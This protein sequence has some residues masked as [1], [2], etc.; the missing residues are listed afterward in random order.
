MK[1]V[2]LFAG[3]LMLAACGGGGGSGGG[4]GIIATSGTRFPNHDVKVSD[5]VKNSNAK[6]LTM[7]SSIADESVRT[8]Y[9]KKALGADGY[10][11]YVKDLRN[12]S[13][14]ASVNNLN[15]KKVPR[16]SSGCNTD[17]ECNQLI[18]DNMKDILEKLAAGNYDL[19]N[20]SVEDIRNVRR[21][22]QIAGYKIPKATEDGNTL[23]EWIAKNKDT[24]EATAKEVYERPDLNAT[25]H[26]WLDSASFRALVTNGASDKMVLDIN[27]DGEI[28]GVK[29][30]DNGSGSSKFSPAVF[31]SSMKRIDDTNEFDAKS[32]FTDG[33]LVM[34]SYAKDLGLK[35][36]DF[37]VLTYNGT[38]GVADKTGYNIPFMGGFDAKRINKSE[39][40]SDVT[41]KG[42]AKGTV[43]PSNNAAKDGVKN[44]TIEDKN[45]TLTFNK[46]NVTETF[47]AKFDNWYDVTATKKAGGTID[48]EFSDGG[49]NIN[50][51]Y[52]FSETKGNKAVLETAYYGDYKQPDEATALIQYQGQAKNPGDGNIQ[53]DGNINMFL[54]FGGTAK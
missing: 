29:F 46:E 54:G 40:E 20:A 38:I 44:L 15:A 41:F 31:Y 6:L 10:D 7:P 28:T 50:E 36:A 37:G 47:N 26:F 17:A 9:L 34:E 24:F 32:A 43:N 42:T 53:D 2:T 33:K 45:A 51:N 52:Q 18:F 8:A 27:D 13:Q 21:A 1:K 16:A 39:L 35:Y 25:K 49:K 30:V 14:T 4:A 19:D 12:A 22:L 3:L 5:D 11:Y 48:I 23:K